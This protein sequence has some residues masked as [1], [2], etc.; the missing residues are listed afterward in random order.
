LRVLLPALTGLLPATL[1][2]ALTR[3]LLLLARLRLT[4]AALLTALLA[5]FVLLASALILF[6]IISSIAGIPHSPTLRTQL[7]SQL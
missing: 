5:A 7:C 4:W 3:L 2:P 1:L 6:H